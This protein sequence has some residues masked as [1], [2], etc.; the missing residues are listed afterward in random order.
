MSAKKLRI[1]WSN[2]ILS[3]IRWLSVCY[4]N[5]LFHNCSCFSNQWW[6]FRIE[7]WYPVVHVY[8]FHSSPTQQTL[9]TRFAD[10]DC[11]EQYR[12]VNQ[13]YGSFYYRN[14]TENCIPD[15]LKAK[16]LKRNTRFMDWL[17]FQA[18]CKPS[19]ACGSLFPLCTAETV[20]YVCLKMKP[21]K[22]YFYSLRDIG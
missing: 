1:L 11:S 9:L 13:D 8:I 5:F 19:P 20:K 6:S 2:N 12:T 10:A 16:S 18:K 15:A 3:R 7:F 4:I 21:K 22:A 14:I 17:M